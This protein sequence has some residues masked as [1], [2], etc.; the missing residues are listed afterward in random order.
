VRRSGA[1]CAANGE[2]AVGDVVDLAGG[3]LF[4]FFVDEGQ[5][6]LEGEGRVGLGIGSCVGL[7]VGNLSVGAECDWVYLWGGSGAESG[8]RDRAV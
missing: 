3:S 6:N 1:E 5:A 7:G 2:G 8:S 4:L